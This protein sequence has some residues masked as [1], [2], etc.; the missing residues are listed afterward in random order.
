M[1]NLGIDIKLVIAQ[2]VSFAIFYV[3]F[4]KFISTPLLK[5][6]KDQKEQEEL[7]EK[8]ALDLAERNEKLEK[9]D[10]EMDR[11]RKKALDKALVQ[12]KKDADAVR[13]ELIEDAKKE[14]AIIITKARELMDEER[15]HMYKEM[16]KQIADV[17]IMMVD[18]ALHEYLTPDAKKAVTK[19]IISHVPETK[20]EN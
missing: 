5:Y 11:E 14:A 18:K 15:E 19:H 16:R 1:E 3:V 6:L 10:R 8:L 20:I 7:R 9:K 17:S 13:L 2:M 4:R 12:G